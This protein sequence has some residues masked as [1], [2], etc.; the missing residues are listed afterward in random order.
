MPRPADRQADASRWRAD[1]H[2]DDLRARDNGRGLRHTVPGDVL[3]GNQTE[4]LSENSR[5]GMVTVFE[6]GS[7]AV[8]SFSIAFAT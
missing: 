6:I 3:V 7:S 4:A 8:A 5:T 2:L 1:L